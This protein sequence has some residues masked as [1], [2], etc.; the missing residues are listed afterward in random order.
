MN[1][2]FVPNFSDFELVDYLRL[3]NLLLIAFIVATLILYIV[4]TIVTRKLK[5]KALLYPHIRDI[6]LKNYHLLKIT[7]YFGCFLII[8]YL[9]TKAFLIIVE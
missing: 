2:V 6:V 9:I 3:S 7:N 1:I 5:C 4:I 8:L